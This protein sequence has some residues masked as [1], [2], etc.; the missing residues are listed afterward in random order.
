VIAG[1]LWQGAFGWQGFGAPAPF[2][3]GAAL[4]LVAAILML[5]WKTPKITPGS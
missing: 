3:F 5:A 4:S 2:L 1:V